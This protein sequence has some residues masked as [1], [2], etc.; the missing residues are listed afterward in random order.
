MELLKALVDLAM[1]P[2][3]AAPLILG[4]FKFAVE[5]YKNK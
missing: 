1:N 4:A 3:I 5:T 2:I